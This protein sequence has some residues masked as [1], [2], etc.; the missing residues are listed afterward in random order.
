MTN[1]TDGRTDILLAIAALHYVVRPKNAA[2]RYGYQSDRG[3]FCILRAHGVEQSVI[4]SAR[5]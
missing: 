3:F 5:Q 2:A 4:Y 1:Y